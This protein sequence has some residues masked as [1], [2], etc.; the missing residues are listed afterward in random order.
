MHNS[1]ERQRINKERT[2]F[3]E[4]IY[5]KHDHTRS[6]S[7]PTLI[8]YSRSLLQWQRE[9]KASDEPIYYVSMDFSNYLAISRGFV[10]VGDDLKWVIGAI[11]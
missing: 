4:K 1:K 5:T 2:L 10:Y 9:K 8:T 6:T 7:V 11:I 3:H